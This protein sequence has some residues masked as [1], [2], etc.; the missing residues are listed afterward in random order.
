MVPAA[1]RMHI[2]TRLIRFGGQYGASVRPVS[3]AYQYNRLVGRLKLH[4]QSWR[5]VESI[6]IR[7]YC[8]SSTKAPH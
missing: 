6:I 3:Q 5:G 2:S 1:V 7:L 8:L 4:Y